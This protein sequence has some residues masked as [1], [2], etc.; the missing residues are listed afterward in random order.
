MSTRVDVIAPLCAPTRQVITGIVARQL[1]EYLSDKPGKFAE[2]VHRLEAE[3][4]YAGADNMKTG[5][6]VSVW[7]SDAYASWGEQ[8]LL[9]MGYREYRKPL[10]SER[11]LAWLRRRQAALPDRLRRARRGRIVRVTKIPAGAELAIEGAAD[12]CAPRPWKSRRQ[13]TVAA[14]T[15]RQARRLAAQLVRLVSIMQELRNSC[16]PTP[17]TPPSPSSVPAPRSSASCSA[18]ARRSSCTAGMATGP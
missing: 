12:S 9:S 13:K 8:L 17:K 3:M 11:G 1:S 5:W 6:H 2:T 10:T 14:Q 16:P 4:M 7:F 18:T 15:G